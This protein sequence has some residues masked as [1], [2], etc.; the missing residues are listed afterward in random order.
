MQRVR[1]N[2]QLQPQ[3]ATYDQAALASLLATSVE[4]DSDNHAPAV[5]SPKMLGGTM[6]L[7]SQ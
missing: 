3:V 6:Y 1:Q 4:V 7:N 2:Q 5:K